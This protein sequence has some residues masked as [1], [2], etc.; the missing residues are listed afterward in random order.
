[1]LFQKNDLAYF[2]KSCQ[3][4]CCLKKPD[5]FPLIKKFRSQNLPCR[6]EKMSHLCNYLTENL[7]RL[8]KLAYNK[9]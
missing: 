5:M 1:M 2:L 4:S 7:C 8:C 3:K 6:L 9:T